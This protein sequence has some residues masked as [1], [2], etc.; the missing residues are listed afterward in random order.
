MTDEITISVANIIL[1]VLLSMG[2]GFV[3]NWLF[4]KSRFSEMRREIDSL[5]NQ[6]SMPV[7]QTVNINQN[8]FMEV[9]KEKGTVHYGTKYGTLS[10]RMGEN[11]ETQQD[12][13]SWLARNDLIAPLAENHTGKASR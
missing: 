1:G 8:E 3:I 5:N 2:T 12:I 7:N 9:E 13:V 4:H 6:R 11:E 10:V